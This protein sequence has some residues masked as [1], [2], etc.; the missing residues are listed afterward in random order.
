MRSFKEINEILDK[1]SNLNLENTKKIYLLGGTGAGKT[2]LVLNT[3]NTIEYGFPSISG[4]RTTI[5]PT[6]YVIQKNLSFKTTIVIKEKDEI[7][8]SI[9]LLIDEAIKKALDDYSS[10]KKKSNKEI[11]ENIVYKLSESADERFR[12]NYMVCEDAFEKQAIYIQNEIIPLI[13]SISQFNE[14]L[15]DGEVVKLHKQNI[16]KYFL[17]EIEKTFKNLSLDTQLF[18]EKTIKIE[19]INNKSK[20]INRTKELLKNEFGS[21]TTL[22]EYVR[23]EGEKLLAD[24]LPSNLEFMLIDGEG[25]G[26]SLKEKRDIL[27]VRHYDFFDY[28]NEI[29]LL[30]EGEKPFVSGGQ[31]AIESIFLNGY[32]DKFKLIFSKADLIP[33]N[34]NNRY[35]RKRLSN[36]EDALKIQDIIFNIENTDTYRVESLHEKQTSEYSKGTIKRLFTNIINKK[37]DDFE[38]LEYDFNDFFI[39]LDTKKFVSN[40]REELDSKHWMTIKAFTNRMY[41]K[42][43]EFNDIKPI[44]K[45]L[46]FIMQDMNLFLK[47]DDELRSSVLNS[48][49]KIKQELSKRLRKYIYNE[50]IVNETH[51]WKQAFNEWGEGSHKKRKDFIFKNII[52]DFLPSQNNIEKFKEFRYKI[53]SLLLDSG[54]EELA[55]AYKIT[56]QNIDIKKIYKIKNFNWKV[57]GDDVNILIGKNGTGKSSILK[58]IDATINKKNEVLDKFYN[59]SVELNI[60]RHYGEE[61]TRNLLVTKQ[62][63]YPDVKSILVDTFDSGTTLDKELKGLFNEFKDYYNGIKTTFENNTKEIR[64]KSLEII[65]NITNASPEELKDFQDLTIESNQIKEKNYQHLNLFKEI[66]DNFYKDTKKEIIFDDSLIKNPK[67]PLLVKFIDSDMP[68][69]SDEEK[70]WRFITNLSSGEKQLL[71]IFLTIII[72]NN[73]P[74][75][76]LLDEPETSLHVE[77]QAMLIENIQKLN[78]NIQIIIA[79]HNPLILLNRISNE[80]GVINIDDEEVK[81]NGK[82]TKYLDISSILLE[83]FGLSSLIGSQMQEDIKNFTKLKLD[84]DNLDE[85]QKEELK[86]LHKILDNSLVGEIIYNSK[87]FIFLNYLKEHKDIDFEQYEKINDD[88][89]KDFLSEFGDFYRD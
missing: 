28:C 6:E 20:F 17:E 85:I 8:D 68:S 29:I 82:G 43:V 15:L 83:Y 49:N 30:E 39:S 50:L 11:I 48:Q 44:T 72:E 16:L 88:E 70:E 54:V 67:I 2:S 31:G 12:L 22:V 4:T 24:W 61:E 35:L 46:T 40:L 64:K 74:F 84:E 32:E 53:K 81:T 87:Y 34:D 77:W 66:I 65:A 38:V 55:I 26:H 36:L 75:I 3:L 59:P 33:D 57:E 37:D 51:L 71:I 56:I 21:L 89:M 73:K 14:T 58:L 41:K 80:I 52:E 79:T 25:I 5:F 69:V 45:I 10:D 19:G 76:L 18:Q 60:L 27:S 47:K 23:I 7:I 62:K 13:N 1:S 78:S 86:R 42:D 9:N 63:H